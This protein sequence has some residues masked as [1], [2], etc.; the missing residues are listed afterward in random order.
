MAAGRAAIEERETMRAPILVVTLLLAVASMV[1]AARA[2][3]PTPIASCP[4]T[5]T[6]SE[7]Y[8]VSKDL[9][10]AGT[11]ITVLTNG[12]TIDL[13]GHTITGNGTGFGIVDGQR[14]NGLFQKDITL[15][16]GTVTQFGV[17]ISVGSTASVTIMQ[18]TAQTNTDVGIALGSSSTVINATSIKNGGNGLN[19]GAFTSFVSLRADW[20]GGDGANGG[21][22]N[23]FSGVEASFNTGAGINT[24]YNLTVTNSGSFEFRMGELAAGKRLGASAWS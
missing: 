11:C 2:A 12:V 10:S 19:L 22:D 6:I 20:N 18:I 13:A 5:I 23:S 14:V 4:Y 1:P 15:E 9:S 3:S 8:A 7:S 17:G 16:N 21:F 24:Q